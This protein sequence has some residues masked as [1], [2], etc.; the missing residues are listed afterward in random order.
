MVYTLAV[1]QTA[2]KYAQ[3]TQ[4]T[5]QK[6]QLHAETLQIQQR[7]QHRGKARVPAEVQGD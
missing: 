3:Q 5:E 7:R 2:S 6:A 1:T 4:R